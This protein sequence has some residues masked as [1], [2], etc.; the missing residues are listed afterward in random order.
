MNNNNY[1]D[2]QTEGARILAI[3]EIFRDLYF[4][5]FEKDQKKLLDDPI[6]CRDWIIKYYQF[7]GNLTLELSAELEERIK[8][9]DKTAIISAREENDMIGFISGAETQTKEN[10]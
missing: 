4:I 2:I 9:I 3:S 1:Y 7:V 6:L 8:I 10:E 5:A